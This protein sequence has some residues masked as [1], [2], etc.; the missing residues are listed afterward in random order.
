MEWEICTCVRVC[1]CVGIIQLHNCINILEF[2]KPRILNYDTDA[3]A[4]EST[5]THSATL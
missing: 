4:N 1:V 2:A 5:Q 3:H